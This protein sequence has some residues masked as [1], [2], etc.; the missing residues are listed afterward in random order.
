MRKYS[1]VKIVTSDKAIDKLS[2]RETFSRWVRYDENLASFLMN[3]NKVKLDK[4]RFVGA[5][6]LALS[7]TVMYDF[8]YKYMMEKYKDCKLLFT[9]T[10][11]FCYS[12]PGVSRDD[13]HA[14]MKNSDYFDCSNYSEKSG[15]FSDK[16]E[17]VPGKFKD[18]CPDPPI[19]EFI[20]LR[21]KMYSLKLAGGLNKARAK[22]VGRL[23]RGEMTHEDYYNSLFEN[24]EYFCKDVK[25][26]HTNHQLETQHFIK[27]SLSPYNDKK[28]IQ[29]N[30]NNFTSYSFGHKAISQ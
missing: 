2:S 4:P 20:G 28:W 7:K 5:A 16:N 11:S 21:A 1:D 6:I 19:E 12:I 27:K 25:I 15:M 22:G 18:E 13:F 3:K 23:V 24:K 10:D 30:G 29:K 26:G 14:E 9:D 8:H 17:M